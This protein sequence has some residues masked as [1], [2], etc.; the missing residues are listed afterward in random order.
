MGTLDN[1]DFDIRTYDV[2]GYSDEM[3]SEN[4]GI[5]TSMLVESNIGSNQYICYYILFP[6]TLLG[7]EHVN[8]ET[9][10]VTPEFE[11]P[12]LSIE[13]NLLPADFQLLPTFPNPFNPIANIEYRLPLNANIE[14]II[15]D[16]RGRQVETLINNYQTAGYH[17]ITWN[18]SSF[19]S[20]VYLIRMESGEFIQ[21]QKLV[22]VK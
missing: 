8:N 3:S 16:I 2:F 9:C 18:A 22:L 20:G 4:L 15:Y 21:T 5:E 10:I 11:S 19:P 6:P 13:N 14:L 7:F 1:L 12:P 17:T